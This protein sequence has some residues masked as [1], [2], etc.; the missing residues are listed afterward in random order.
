M[1]DRLTERLTELATIQKG[2]LDGHTGEGE[3]VDPA[4]L[5]GLKRFLPEWLAGMPAPHLYATAEGF[6]QAEWDLPEG[7]AVSA[8][9][10]AV[11]L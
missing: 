10:H 11:K 9:F 2:W 7:W 1:P 6:V 4:T 5:E 3:P 8:V